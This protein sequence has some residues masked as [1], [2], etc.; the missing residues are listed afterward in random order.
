MFLYVFA[1]QFPTCF[2]LCLVILGDIVLYRTLGIAACL[3]FVFYMF[4]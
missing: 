3:T 2:G 1:L 4:L